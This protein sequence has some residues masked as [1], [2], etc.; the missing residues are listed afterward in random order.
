LRSFSVKNYP[1][2]KEIIREVPRYPSSPSAGFTPFIFSF[3][4]RSI[5]GSFFDHISLD[6]VMHPTVGLPSIEPPFIEILSI[7]PPCSRSLAATI[8]LSAANA[9]VWGR[10]DMKVAPFD[11][12]DFSFHPDHFI[13]VLLICRRS[14]ASTRFDHK[15]VVMTF[16]IPAFFNMCGPFAF[17]P[18]C[19]SSAGNFMFYILRIH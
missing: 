15:P 10:R 9:R 3:R 6:T 13:F 18:F 5:V 4:M 19:C 8:A 12:A 2:T 17:P 11:R 14:K 1:L 16:T 7:P